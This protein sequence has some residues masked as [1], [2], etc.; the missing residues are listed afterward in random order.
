MSETHDRSLGGVI[1]DKKGEQGQIVEISRYCNQHSLTHEEF[2]VAYF[3]ALGSPL[4]D[5]D[6]VLEEKRDVV[7]KLSEM[8]KDFFAKGLP[9]NKVAELMYFKRQVAEAS[10]RFIQMVDVLDVTQREKML[11]KNIVQQRRS[12]TLTV[13]QKGS[14]TPI[15]IVDLTKLLEGAELFDYVLLDMFHRV[16]KKVGTGGKIEVL[17]EN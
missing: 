3:V 11:L 9:L 4:T 7:R 8:M 16:Q 6:T 17:W 15:V 12:G 14:N 2:E 1:R 13:R 10:E 5:M